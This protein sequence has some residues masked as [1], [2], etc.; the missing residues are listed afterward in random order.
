M[1]DSLPLH[2][3]VGDYIREACAHGH[4]EMIAILAPMILKHRSLI[5][6]DVPRGGRIDWQ[7]VLFCL[8]L[9]NM[10]WKETRENI[11]KEKCTRGSGGPVPAH[12]YTNECMY[13]IIT[14]AFSESFL[15]ADADGARRLG[16][17]R[18]TYLGAATSQSCEHAFGAIDQ[19]AHGCLTGENLQ[20]ITREMLVTRSL[21]HE[22]ECSAVP[23][24]RV[25]KSGAAL[26]EAAVDDAAEIITIRQGFEVALNI[27]QLAFPAIPLMLAWPESLGKHSGAVY[28]GDVSALLAWLP[29]PRTEARLRELVSTE[30][31]GMVSFRAKR[32]V[33][34]STE[35]RQLVSG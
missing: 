3:V 15:V 29:H 9:L 8:M 11:C 16:K 2:I 7:T 35:F 13:K 33:R 25:R 17:R 19:A 26:P 31:M 23:C 22:M 5:D 12:F 18:E 4:P 20:R 30:Q 34:A 14:A 10:I 21:L 24:A 6:D 28:F 27:Y 32:P 1:E